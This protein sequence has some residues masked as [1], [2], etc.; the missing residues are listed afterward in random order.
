MLRSILIVVVALL[1]LASCMTAE[2]AAQA[3]MQS[4]QAYGFFPGT[5]EFAQCRLQL[6]QARIAQQQAT[7]AALSQVQIQPIDPAPFMNNR[8]FGG[9]AMNCTS[10]RVGMQ[11]Y[12]NCF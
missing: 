12:T 3:D 2:Q 1:P 9:N 11:T 6:H 5:T 7:A 10:T 4:C 8:S